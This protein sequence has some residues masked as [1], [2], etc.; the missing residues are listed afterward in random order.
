MPGP[1]APSTYGSGQTYGSAAPTTY[2]AAP[3]GSYG[4]AAPSYAPPPPGQFGQGSGGGQ[5]DAP[6]GP[7]GG[8]YGSGGGYGGSGSSYGSAPAGSYGSSS[9]GDSNRD[10]D[11]PIVTPQRKPRRG[12]IIAL[13]VTA[14][15]VVVAVGGYV[16]ISLKRGDTDYS[17]GKCV[18]QNGS[19]AT[20]VDCSV[21]GAYRIVSTVDNEDGCTDA[22]QPSLAVTDPSGSTTYRCLAPAAGP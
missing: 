3:G 10:G 20:V 17:V 13:I 21:N 16:G 2:G 1:S 4:S 9:G 5:Y 6:G 18:Q 19:K 15:L 11:R 7:S 14:I 8:T 12:L 22:K